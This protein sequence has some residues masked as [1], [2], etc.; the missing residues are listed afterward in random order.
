MNDFSKISNTFIKNNEWI[1]YYAF[2]NK[3]KIYK[4]EDLLQELRI[5]LMEA[6]V[7][8]TKKKA[9]KCSWKTFAVNYIRWAYY[10]NYLTTLG[11]KKRNPENSGFTILNLDEM[12]DINDDDKSDLHKMLNDGV[13]V[14]D[15]AENSAFYDSVIKSIDNVRNREIVI[16]YTQGFPFM[17]IA[18]RYNLSNQ[19]VGRIF[20]DE[21]NEI[22]QYLDVKEE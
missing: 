13:S 10:G 11:Y 18:K 4:D 17:Q 14:S 16:L 5:W 22:K 2:H 8:Y 1:I 3:P 15:I 6:K 19:M 20:H 21:M 7:K 9:K 12:I